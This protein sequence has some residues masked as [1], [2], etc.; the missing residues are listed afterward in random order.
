MAVRLGKWRRVAVGDG[1]ALAL[2]GSRLAVASSARLEVVH[3][4]TVVAAVEA[5]WPAP[6]AP[7]FQDDQV[8]W[9]PGV[10]TLSTG[11]YRP[12]TAAAP[13]T[14]PGGGERP[15]IYAWSADGSRLVAGFGGR[16]VL[17]SAGGEMLGPVPTPS[18]LAPVAAFAG[19]DRA[20][21]E[22]TDFGVQLVPI[23]ALSADTA[24]R[25]LL[26]VAL[27][28]AVVSID[29]VA[30]AVIDVWR[31]AWASVAVAPGG[32][33]VAVLASTGIIAVADLVD[34]RFAPRA[35]IAPPAGSRPPR[36]IAF[37]GSA[38]AVCGGGLVA[39]A[40]EATDQPH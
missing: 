17:L 11:S 3:G 1:D 38:V 2:H 12:L 25:R 20:L 34:G 26:A 37:D 18:G 24:E 13:K 5:P 22:L 19:R 39:V 33:H 21:V 23:V 14:W 7:Q 35:E 9:G 28:Q 27:N 8:L 31:G 6:G 15:S 32:E 29:L 4:A 36:A 10:L 40:I 16:A 30:G